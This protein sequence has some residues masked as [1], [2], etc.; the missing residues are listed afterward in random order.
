MEIL[1][2]NGSPIQNLKDFSGKLESIFS[3]NPGDYTMNTH[4]SVLLL[5]VLTPLGLIE[6]T[7]RN[8]SISV[9]NKPFIL[10][11]KYGIRIYTDPNMRFRDLRI[12]YKDN[13]I[14]EIK[15]GESALI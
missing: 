6:N 15:S 10:A 12:F 14:L 2:L 3:K 5:D 8:K 7:E 1:E 13:P 4:L 9:D 11:E